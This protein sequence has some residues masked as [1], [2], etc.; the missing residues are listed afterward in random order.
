[1]ENF[2][3]FLGTLKYPI[4]GYITL[5]SLFCFKKSIYIDNIKKLLKENWKK[6]INILE[7]DNLPHSRVIFIEFNP[8]EKITLIE[9][10]LVWYRERNASWI[11]SLHVINDLFRLIKDIKKKYNIS[12]TI[13]MKMIYIY[14]ASVFT[15]ILSNSLWR[16]LPEKFY[17]KIINRIIKITNTIR[18]LKHKIFNH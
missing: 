11:S 7:K 2:F 14:Y 10:N 17:K 8:Q 9:K 15:H 6:Y 1:M 18:A 5:I 13:Y 16:I 4:N 3:N 12:K